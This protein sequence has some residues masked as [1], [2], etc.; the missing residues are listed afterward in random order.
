[1][2][3]ESIVTFQAVMSQIARE[4]RASRQALETIA[5]MRE[6]HFQILLYSHLHR[7]YWLALSQHDLLTAERILDVL[8]LNQPRY[9]A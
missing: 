1:M 4:R 6:W 3:L 8:Q 9:K 5:R 2:S 7:R